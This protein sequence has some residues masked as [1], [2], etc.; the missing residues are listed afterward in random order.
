ML[1]NG[2]PE[3]EIF[4]VVQVSSSQF[5]VSSSPGSAK[6]S[7]LEESDPELRSLLTEFQ[8]VFQEDL[9][10]GL[11]PKREVDHE[12]EILPNSSPPHRPLYQLSPAELVAARE[13]VD[14]LLRSGK[15]RPSKSPYGSPI[16]FVKEPG[17]ALRG[18]VDY[19]GLNRITKRNNAPLPRCDEMFDRL[20]KARFF[21]KLDL[22]TVFHLIRLRL[23]DIGK[24]V[25]NSKYGQFEYLVMP[26]GLCNAPATIQSLMN[27]IFYD[28]IDWFLVVYIDDILIYS[29]TREEHLG[30]IRMVLDRLKKHQLYASPKKCSFMSEEAEFLGLIVGRDGI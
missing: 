3:V 14:N 9:P 19:R 6:A 5:T 30:H 18:V 20:G 1:R 23:S 28:Y 12:I 7:L 8:E 25:F 21:S 27:R 13:H 24:T 16:F 4:R 17:Q 2:R 26:M 22:K 15:I 10:H 11:P 29:N